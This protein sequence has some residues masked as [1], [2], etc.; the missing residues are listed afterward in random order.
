MNEVRYLTVDGKVGR[1]DCS[2]PNSSHVIHL[3][4]SDLGGFAHAV[5]LTDGPLRDNSADREYGRRVELSLSPAPLDV[6]A[7]AYE[8][9]GLQMDAVLPHTPEVTR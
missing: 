1:I 2:G 6:L 8:L 7:K 3:A 5:L 9:A 4:L